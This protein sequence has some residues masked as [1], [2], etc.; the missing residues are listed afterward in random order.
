MTQDNTKHRIKELYGQYLS[1]NITRKEYD[2]MYEL[3]KGEPDQEMMANII[4]DT[5]PEFVSSYEPES[6]GKSHTGTHPGNE[7]ERISRRSL[8]YRISAA[9]AVVLLLVAS[10]WML[11]GNGQEW[12]VYSTGY[13][14]TMTVKLPDGSTVELNANSELKWKSDFGQAD[15]R[16]VEFR[17]EGFFNVTHLNGKKFIVHTGSIDVNVLGTE[18]NVETRRD[19]TN[20]FLKEGK[21]VLRSEE[22]QP[23]EM[24]PGD[25][26]RYDTDS[27][28]ISKVS[29]RSSDEVLSWKDGVF[30]FLDLTGI[31][32]LN[33][34][35]DI[36]GQEFIIEVPDRL[37]DVIVVQGLP[38][39]DWD[40][41]KEALELALDIRLLE[42]ADGKIIV[43]EK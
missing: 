20:V 8:F 27:K 36:Y 4:D 23:V 42:S 41:T 35:E 11:N 18:F 34:M 2:E 29:D 9:A 10:V 13:Q 30:T 26:V 32:I 6:I 39:T 24:D 3:M 17:G 25:L 31:Q 22:L 21:V 16:T 15:Q 28:T 14:E 43:K 19:Y 1:G 5:I 37:S 12:M 7:K 33:K 40:F 38:Y